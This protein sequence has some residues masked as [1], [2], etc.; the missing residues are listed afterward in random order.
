MKLR[1]LME[2]LMSLMSEG[3][4]RGQRL[5]LPPEARARYDRQHEF[6]QWNERYNEGEDIR[7]I[8][9]QDY[10]DRHTGPVVT[11]FDR[12]FFHPLPPGYEF[13]DSPY[14]DGRH[15]ER[16]YYDLPEEK[17]DDPGFLDLGG[18]KMDDFGRP[19]KPSDY[20]PRVDEARA[21]NPHITE[22]QIEHYLANTKPGRITQRGRRK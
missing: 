1:E 10:M 13:F 17:R 18:V 3:Q 19:A 8:S 9:A 16:R 5:D 20:D 7:Q 2:P 22:E 14:H 12:N 4:R 15:I 11:P 6:D 21:N